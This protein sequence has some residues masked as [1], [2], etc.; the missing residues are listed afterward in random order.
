M[1]DRVLAVVWNTWPVIRDFQDDVVVGFLDGYRNAR[2]I[3]WIVLNGVD[4]EVTNRRGNERTRRRP[5]SLVPVD[6]DAGMW[7]RVTDAIDLLPGHRRDIDR[8]TVDGIFVV[9]QLQEIACGVSEVDRVHQR[10]VE[11]IEIFA[12]HCSRLVFEKVYHPDSHVQV[13][14]NVVADETVQHQ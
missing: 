6:G 8:F 12:S 7:I 1:E 5:G 3:A 10:A 13:V 2:C 9:E 4:Q 14:S 11:A